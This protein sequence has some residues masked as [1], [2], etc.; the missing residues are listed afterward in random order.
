MCQDY[1][2]EEGDDE[3]GTE[4]DDASPSNAADDIEA[5][6]A[7]N[8]PNAGSRQVTFYTFLNQQ[9]KYKT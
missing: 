2:E 1:E 5:A 9:N 3:V 8:M 6:Q 7:S 4:F